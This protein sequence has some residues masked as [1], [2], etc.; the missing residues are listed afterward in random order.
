MPEG[1]M[2]WLPSI[3]VMAGLVAAGLIGLFAIWHRKCPGCGHWSAMDANEYVDDQQHQNRHC[4]RC[5]ACHSR[6]RTAFWGWFCFH[7]SAWTAW[8]PVNVVDKGK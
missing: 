2:H 4:R 6:Q 1:W 5:S 8:S 7:C 3:I